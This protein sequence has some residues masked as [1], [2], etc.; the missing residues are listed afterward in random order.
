MNEVEDGA[1]IPVGEVGDDDLEYPSSEQLLLDCPSDE[2]VG[3]RFPEFSVETDM[4]NPQFEVG[5]RFR[6]MQE[7]RKAVRTYDA[8]N[9]YN[10]KLKFHH[11]K[12]AQGVCKLGC[13]L[14]I[15]ASK[16]STTETVQVISYTPKHTCTRGKTNRHCNYIFLASRYSE[17]FKA[18][19]GWMTVNF[20][21]CEG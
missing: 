9:G 7:F 2:K 16:M 20:G 8:L 13:N 18:D 6:S 14:R 10:V 5:Q 1:A 15:W 19:P 17:Q 21:Y 4:W 12:R 11:K 3:Y